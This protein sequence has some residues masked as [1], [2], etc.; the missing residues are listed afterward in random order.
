MGL[1][2]ELERYNK[3][4][5][6]YRRSKPPETAEA[7]RLRELR[8]ELGRLEV[9]LAPAKTDDVIYLDVETVAQAL[10][11]K[12][13]VEYMLA[14]VERRD[15]AEKERRAA[16]SARLEL[17]R[18]QA[19]SDPELLAEVERRNKS[20]AYERKWRRSPKSYGPLPGG[21]PDSYRAKLGAV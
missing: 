7:R 21:F 5:E 10:A 19:E 1:E 13:A 20:D 12:P 4:E 2:S 14:V 17:F 9:M 8:E 6:F 16:E 15:R 3:S 11:R 18:E